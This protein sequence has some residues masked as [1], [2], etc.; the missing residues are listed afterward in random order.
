MFGTIRSSPWLAVKLVASAPDCT[1]PCS[2]PAAPASLC[3]SET[4]GTAPQTF[5]RRSAIHASASSPIEDDGV[6]G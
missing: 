4:T 6:M 3:I 5:G 1:A 2:A